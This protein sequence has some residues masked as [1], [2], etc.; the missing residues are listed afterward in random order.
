MSLA[1]HPAD[2]HQGFA[3]VALGVARRVGQRHEHLPC[4]EAVLPDVV[5]DDGV[6]AVEAILIPETLEDALGGMPLLPGNPVI[7]FQDSVYDTREGLLLSLS[8]GWDGAAGPF[9]GSPAARS[10]PASCAP[11]PGAG[12]T[13]GRIPECSSPP[14]SPPG[15]P[16]DIRPPCTSVAPSAGLGTTLMDDGGRSVFQ[17]PFC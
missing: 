16:V 13:S 7:L 9:S 11:C 10:R 1:L 6:P 2:D 3:E 15:E 12:R 5:L 14:P 17:P 8:K 4:P